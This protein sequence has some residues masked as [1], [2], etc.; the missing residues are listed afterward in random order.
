MGVEWAEPDDPAIGGLDVTE[1]LDRLSRAFWR[2]LVAA[3]GA[4]V[5]LVGRLAVSHLVRR[6]EDLA[7]HLE[8]LGGDKS[9]VETMEVQA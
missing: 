4:G 5:P 8:L 9:S 3:D 6:V 1:M 7:D 2:V